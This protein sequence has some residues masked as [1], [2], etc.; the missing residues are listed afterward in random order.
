M[1][2]LFASQNQHKFE[3]IK[4]LLPPSVELLS[5]A[6]MHFEGH[7]P[8]TTPTLSG[9]ALQKAAYIYAKYK[10]P[11]FADD[12]GLEIEALG[13]RPGVYSAR[14]AGLNKSAGDNMAKVLHQMEGVTQ[15][16]AVFKTVIA[17]AGTEEPMF[18][19][20]IVNGTITTEK[21]GNNGFGYDPIFMP[22]GY[23]VTFAQ[24]SMQ[25]K[26]KLSHRANAVLKFGKWLREQAG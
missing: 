12:T 19:E 16:K 21:R 9:N 10:M 26:N 22:D 13:G 20:G 15:R 24:M 23:A 2:L 6:D 18:F 8:E 11:C 4:P 3:E 17:L 25:E 5:L 7:I 1:Q 14:Y